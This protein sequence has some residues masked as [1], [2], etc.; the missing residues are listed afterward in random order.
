M[1]YAATS[2]GLF[3]QRSTSLGGTFPHRARC[4]FS[5]SALGVKVQSG[6]FERFWPGTSLPRPNPSRLPT[7]SIDLPS[8]LRADCCFNHEN[9]LYCAA[10]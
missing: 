6:R 5:L 9:G 2:P 4:H 1:Y 8:N 3:V 7:A 10:A